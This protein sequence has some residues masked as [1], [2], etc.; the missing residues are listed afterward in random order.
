[1]DEISD[2]KTAQR[3]VGPWV[4]ETAYADSLVILCA[5]PCSLLGPL[6]TYICW[7]FLLFRYAL[8]HLWKMS[9]VLTKPYLQFVLY[10]TWYHDDRLSLRL[11]VV[12]LQILTVLKSTQCVY[13]FAILRILSHT[14]S[15]TR[16]SPEHSH[17]YNAYA[18]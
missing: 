11:A 5:A 1:M 15:H 2:L 4:S 7:V 10:W 18:T 9:C 6:L 17:G 16:F 14:L 13:V 3:L 8:G 12:G